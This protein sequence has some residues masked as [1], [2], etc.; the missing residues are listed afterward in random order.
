MIQDIA[1]APEPVYRSR[2]VGWM[3]LRRTTS[4]GSTDLLDCSCAQVIGSD[5]C[6]ANAMDVSKAATML[7]ASSRSRHHPKL[8]PFPSHLKMCEPQWNDP[9]IKR[10]SSTTRCP[11][12]VCLAY[13]PGR[14][15][16][17]GHALAIHGPRVPACTSLTQASLSTHISL[18]SPNPVCI[19]KVVSRSLSCNLTRIHSMSEIT[20]TLYMFNCH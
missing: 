2:L 12:A 17:A 7:S 3:L 14:Y 4:T 18:S 5:Q 1:H 20:R 19:S 10:T 11:N 16:A 15:L 6:M 13:P 8:E 9:S